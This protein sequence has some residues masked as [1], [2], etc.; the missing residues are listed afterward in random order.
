M[1]VRFPGQGNS[2]PRDL[3][4]TELAACEGFFRLFHG[5][6]LTGRHQDQGLAIQAERMHTDDT[7]EF[8]QGRTGL[9]TGA[10]SSHAGD[11]DFPLRHRL[12]DLDLD[13]LRHLDGARTIVVQQLHQ[14]VH[15][16][17]VASLHAEVADT[18]GVEDQVFDSSFFFQD[19]TD[20]VSK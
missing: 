20:P 19:R 16:R 17:C 7:G 4:W 5:Q 9:D 1:P 8:L 13:K 6:R 15:L 10:T 11:S 14:S 3:A 12:L 18:S 2:G